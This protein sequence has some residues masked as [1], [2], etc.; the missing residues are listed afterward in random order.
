[1]TQCSIF[2]A[3][4]K[5]P[6]EWNA[7]HI[8]TWLNWITKTFK[9]EPEPVLERFPEN[10]EEL[11]QMTEADFWVCAGSREGGKTLSKHLAHMIHSTTGKCSSALSS[12]ADPGVCV[13]FCLHIFA[14]EATVI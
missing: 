13:L 2:I 4:F 12:D 8:K 7:T 5:D 11:V 6:A 9:I 3:L 14:C 1:M 10:G